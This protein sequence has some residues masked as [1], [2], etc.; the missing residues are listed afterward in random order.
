MRRVSLRNSLLVS[1]PTPQYEP[2]DYRL[3][4]SQ[5]RPPKHRFDILHLLSGTVHPLLLTVLVPVVPGVSPGTC[6]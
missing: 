4:H 6:A 2:E 1:T 5:N 3:D